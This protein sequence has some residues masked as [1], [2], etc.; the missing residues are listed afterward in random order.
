[1]YV[2]STDST[3]TQ[4]MTLNRAEPLP[5]GFC[6]YTYC[7]TA[8]RGQRGNTWECE[9]GKNIAMSLLL[10]PGQLLS[11][12]HFLL[13]EQVAI[14]IVSALSPL[15]DPQRLTI[16]WPNDIYYDDFKL[17]GT[18]IEN[19]FSGAH[20]DYSIAGIGL[21]VNQTT[22]R[23]NAPNPISLAGILKRKLELPPIVQAICRQV[24]AA[25]RMDHRQT[26]QTYAAM[27]YRR[28]GMHPFRLPD[29]STFKAAINTVRT[30]GRIEL[31][32]EDGSLQTFYFKE[33]G[34]CL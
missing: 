20:L 14:G 18:L 19:T 6:L 30:D 8:G 5:D 26:Q 25:R 12:E 1:M 27:L 7:Q 10:R 29:G 11:T 3:N 17:S 15:L 9:A 22:F 21:N 2:K 32:R 34:Y 28:Q 4:L 13:A 24:D 23:S 33:V 31:K 16:K